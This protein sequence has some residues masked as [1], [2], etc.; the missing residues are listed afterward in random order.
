M[1]WTRRAQSTRPEMVSLLLALGHPGR[2]SLQGCANDNCGI[3][4]WSR[5]PFNVCVRMR[6]Y[7]DKTH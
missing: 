6:F 5:D 7:K 4:A 2:S 3:E 1:G